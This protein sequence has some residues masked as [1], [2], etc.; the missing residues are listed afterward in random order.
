MQR[1]VDARGHI[2]RL[3]RALSDDAAA[4]AAIG[5][6]DLSAFAP[7]RSYDPRLLGAQLTPDLPVFRYAARLAAAMMAGA[8]VAVS[9]GGAG[10]GNW[11]LLT[12][13]VVMRAS[14]GWT[15]QRRDDRIVGTLVGCVIAAVAVAYAPIGALVVVQGLAL[16]VTHGFIRSNYRLA[17]VGASVMA[18]VSLHLINPAEAAPVLTRLA[19]TLV[20]A[21][22]AHLF[23]HVWPS[24]EFDEAPRLAARL[25]AQIDAFAAVDVA[26]G[27]V[28]PGL[29]PGA[30]GRHRGDRRAVRFGRAHGR[31][32]ARGAAR[33]RR[34]GGDADRRPCRR[35]PSLGDAAGAARGRRRRGRG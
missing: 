32:A 31:R 35:R 21:A 12:I 22:I 26:L 27:R 14:Y 13:A 6:V 30:Q 28:G 5:Q 24:W 15:R 17:S 2:R 11:V 33:P 7:R 4:K 18:L 20:G 10:H 1:L 8:I 19:D 34:N 25:I 9:L 3:E 29:S 16:A 23:S